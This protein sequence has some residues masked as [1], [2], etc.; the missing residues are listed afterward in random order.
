MP[1][2]GVGP[3]PTPGQATL[4]PSAE[5]PIAQD[6]TTAGPIG[7]GP[8]GLGPLARGLFTHADDPAPAGAPEAHLATPPQFAGPSVPAQAVFTTEPMPPADAPPEVH[9]ERAA[10]PPPHQFYGA[11]PVRPAELEEPFPV[12]ARPQ[13]KPAPG[14]HSEAD[15]A[16]A[17]ARRAAPRTPRARKAAESVSNEDAGTHDGERSGA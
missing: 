13:A 3:Q 12:P 7:A 6:P 5:V 8:V 10:E 16:P 4:G 1:G 11:A 2:S 17:R 9:Q 15:E 14:E